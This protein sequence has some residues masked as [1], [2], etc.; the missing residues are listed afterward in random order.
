[1]CGQTASG[2][3]AAR[4]S[5]RS[6]T[7]AFCSS[8]FSTL[9]RSIQSHFLFA[10]HLFIMLKLALIL[11]AIC[12]HVVVI[13][14]YSLN[15]LQVRATVGRAACVDCSL[16]RRR[17]IPGW[18]SKLSRRMSFSL[19]CYT[20]KT[21][22]TKTAARPTCSKLVRTACKSVADVSDRARDVGEHFDLSFAECLWKVCSWAL[23]KRPSP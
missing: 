6:F 15:R 2:S 4:R 23:E 1:M 12:L 19:N 8:F 20:R 18:T 22:S 3:S 7:V 11:L 21:R 9:T 14:C 13:N 5:P 16:A 17:A 10:V